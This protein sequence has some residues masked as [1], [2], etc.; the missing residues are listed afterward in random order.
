METPKM[1]ENSTNRASIST[2][3]T[4]E[5][6][7]LF[8]KKLMENFEKNNARHLDLSLVWKETNDLREL[9][10]Q[11]DDLKNALIVFVHCLKMKLKC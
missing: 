4:L 3:R 2:E 1:S 6:R 8:N 11:L 9:Y 10:S 5:L 7:S